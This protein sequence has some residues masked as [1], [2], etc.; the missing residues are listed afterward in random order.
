MSVVECMKGDSTNVCV[1]ATG[2]GS[3]CALTVVTDVLAKPTFSQKKGITALTDEGWATTV[4][5]AKMICAGKDLLSG[6]VDGVLVKDGVT[7]RDYGIDQPEVS[8]YDPNTGTIKFGK[9]QGSAVIA[10]QALNDY[11]V[12]WAAAGHPHAV[13]PTSFA[14][15]VTCTGAVPMVVGD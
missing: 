1:E 15:L 9:D 3:C 13:Y 8:N 6:V 14:E 11:E 7:Y 10:N 4:G 12:V 2:E 5:E